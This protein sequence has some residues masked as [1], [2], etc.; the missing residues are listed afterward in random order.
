MP[1]KKTV[2]LCKTMSW[3]LILGGL[4][5]GASAQASLTQDRSFVEPEPLLIA[6]TDP[7]P[8]PEEQ[9][10]DLL[11][12]ARRLLRGDEYDLA[13]ETAEQV[14]A[15]DVDNPEAQRLVADAREERAENERVIAERTERERQRQIEG[16]LAIANR[17]LR[18]DNFGEVVTAAQQV[19]AIDADN[20]EAVELL[21][22]AE[23]GATRTAQEEAGR[24]RL[25]QVDTFVSEARRQLRAHDFSAATAAAQR[26][27]ELDPGNSAAQDIIA[28][29][30]QEQAETAQEMLE[31]QIDDLLD[32]ARSQLRAED[33]AGALATAQEI[34]ALDAA[35]TAAQGIIVR[36]E[37]EQTEA[38]AQRDA[39][40]REQRVSDLL[41]R[42]EAERRA[43]DLEAARATLAE[44]AQLD[45][46]NR[47]IRRAA[48]ATDNAIADAD[49]EAA[50]TQRDVE[51]ARQAEAARQAEQTQRAEQQRLAQETQRAE[52][53]AQRAEETQRAE[54][55]RLAEDA[56]R[57][58]ETRRA[59]A[60]RQA[61]E[62]RRAEATQRVEQER[63]AEQQRLAQEQQAT[64]RQA[65]SERLV[66]EAVA[67]ADAGRLEAAADKLRE[68]LVNWPDNSRAQRALPR[69][70]EALR[71][72]QA[73]LAQQ[74]QLETQALIAALLEEGRQA[75]AQ[76]DIITA[77][78]KWR[79]VIE[80]APNNDYA[81][82]YLQETEAEH[83]GAL[84]LEQTEA[85]REA[86]QRE[87]ESRLSTPITITT[88]AE[89]TPLQSFLDNISA[90]TEL[91]FIIADGVEA[92]VIGAFEEQPL[93][94]VL[95]AVIT[96][97][98][99]Q[100]TVEDTII[101]V[102]PHLQTTFYQLNPDDTASLTVFRDSGML[103]Q[104]LYPPDGVSHVAGE[105]YELDTVTG[106]FVITG[107]LDQIDR[108]DQLVGELSG[109][110]TQVLITEM[111]RIREV[112]GERIRTLVEA[113]LEAETTPLNEAW[114]RTIILQ[115]EHLI[116]RATEQEV[117]RVEELLQEFGP[118]G[119]GLTER[120][121]EVS[122]FSLV[123]RRVLRQSEDVARDLA[124]Q[125]V[126]TVRVLL[127]SQTGEDA[128]RRE[129]RRLWYDEFT[130]QLTITDTQDN[131]ELV[132]RYISS[133][134]TLEPRR[135][136]RIVPID[137]QA[138]GTLAGKVADFL[139]IEIRGADSGAS[140][141]SSGGDVVVR[142]LREDDEFT[143]RDMRITLIEVEENDEDDDRDE[144]VTM[145]IDTLM[146]SDE[147]TIEE[148]RSEI[149]DDYRIRI[150]DAR[151]SDSGSGRAEI[152]VSYLGAGAGGT[153]GGT[154]YQVSTAPTGV[155]ADAA[156]EP[157]AEE[158][159][160][161]PVVQADDDTNSLMISV[162]N[163]GDL[164]LIMQ[165][166][167]LLD[168]P[169]P[170]AS[171]E[172]KFVEVN[173]NR[174]RELQNE[175]SLAGIGREGINFS[176]S[177]LSGRFAQDVDEYRNAFEPLLESPL[178]ANLPKGRTVLSL[179]TGGQSPLVWELSFLEAEGVI[180]TV[181]GPHITTQNGE[182]AEFT[183][184]QEFDLLAQASQLAVATT[185]AAYT[186]MVAHPAQLENIDLVEMVITPTITQSGYITLDISTMIIRNFTNNLGQL[187]GNLFGANIRG[188]PSGFVGS[189]NEAA[190]SN[191][192]GLMSSNAKDIITVVR[193]RDGG[194]VVLGGWNLERVMQTSSG[195][196]IL[197]NLPYVGQLFFSRNQDY[198][199]RLTL[200]IFLTARIVD[201]D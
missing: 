125:T 161:T 97:N 113:I 190:T 108:A 106:V 121:L 176:D 142:T 51:E 101:T 87:M 122:V 11:R 54:Q 93:S 44:A 41:D 172:T 144:S 196:P 160:T 116:V 135:I 92:Q 21:A 77:V 159:E 71:E 83:R 26:I 70:V 148:L 136:T 129:G 1:R 177:F 78:E 75:Y 42:A 193:V 61:E 13:I 152:E 141:A 96:A 45:P 162:V 29:A 107:N 43:G 38:A 139:G 195:I 189:P 69:V 132:Q 95:D 86:R 184:T 46:D 185:Q 16:L 50:E 155:P 36:A 146:N 178:A 90:F 111:F 81:L 151:A 109:V 33:H 72:A 79:R 56:Q 192:H 34:L 58:E 24:E 85:E 49:E 199:E 17:S 19:L 119:Q 39:A 82:T 62:A 112:E 171:I 110:S 3:G 102:R 183:I 137:H 175:M 67:L 89:G 9:V 198:L 35:N 88:R 94:D 149:V 103:D 124:E 105:G 187:T 15:I 120:G 194:T 23:A 57:A 138:A 7:A 188:L 59:E 169:I 64:E 114:E 4:L 2:N 143:F 99:L 115:G 157:A 163:P 100:W 131:I 76:G 84:A 25:R 168:V 150:I 53:E 68:A 200:M 133:I 73:D 12:Q 140:S 167:E 55:E 127:Y 48:R 28:Q 22:Q 145:I 6:Q 201:I 156:A 8:D 191:L 197:R 91:D 166:I 31:D 123:P 130:L 170:Q 66:D 182:D 117:R 63:L 47:R 37:Q 147:R 165:A 180:S 32:Q 118:E 74:A 154:Q 20:D 60:A 126:E 40:A 30:E 153:G 104:L 80:I 128:A 14:F 164:D 5:L 18:R 134:P 27:L 174:A 52:Q 179:I 10:R 186:P 173:E 65:T 158:D 98:G 181:N